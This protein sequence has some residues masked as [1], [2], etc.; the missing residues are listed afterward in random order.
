MCVF[1]QLVFVERIDGL[2]VIDGNLF[3]LYG[4]GA[5]FFL[6][7]HIGLRADKFV[8]RKGINVSVGVG[9]V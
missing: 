4:N 3:R 7:R 2:L 1:I 5:D 9:D 8:F 6:F